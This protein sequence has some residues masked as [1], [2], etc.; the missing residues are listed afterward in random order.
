MCLAQEPQR[1]E[2]SEAKP[3]APRSRV[4]HSTTVL[5]KKTEKKKTNNIKTTENSIWLDQTFKWP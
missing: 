5:P 3:A 1:N 2:A 4:K